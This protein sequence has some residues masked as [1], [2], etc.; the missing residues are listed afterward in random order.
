MQYAHELEY[1][2]TGMFLPIVL[3]ESLVKNLDAL[4]KKH[5]VNEIYSCHDLEDSFADKVDQHSVLNG[6][7][8]EDS[9]IK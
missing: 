4:R 3:T 6:L 8:H 7:N 2:Y 1:M 5:H 9:A